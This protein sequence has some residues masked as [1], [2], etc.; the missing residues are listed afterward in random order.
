MSRLARRIADGRAALDP[1]AD[2]EPGTFVHHEPLQHDEGRFRIE[3]ELLGDRTRERVHV[4]IR[5]LGPRQL[6]LVPDTVP[7]VV[8]HEL[9]LED[10]PSRRRSRRY[11]P[12]SVSVHSGLHRSGSV[13]RLCIL[14]ITIG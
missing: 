5:V 14:S 10:R 12:G 9:I 8:L 7:E 6:D 13:A 1:H 2:A 4:H 11:G 3:A